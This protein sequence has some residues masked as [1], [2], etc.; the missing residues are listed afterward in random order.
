MNRF[1]LLPL[2]LLLAAATIVEAQRMTV[3]TESDAARAEFEQARARWAHVD[4]VGV[5]RHLDAALAADPGFAL[6]HLY[7]AASL[8]ISQ[9]AE[10]MR[11][12]EAARVSAG[13]RELIEAVKL[14]NAGD[15]E[16]ERAVY[17]KLAGE[18][19]NDPWPFYHLGGSLYNAERYDD[20]VAAY[21]R[22]IAADA[23]FPGAY[24]LLGYAE[25]QR[26][27]KAA[28]EKAFEQYIRLAPNEANPYDSM[29]EFYMLNGRLNE[30]EAQFKKALAIDPE[31][32]VSSDNLV[33]IALERR[34]ARFEQAV[35]NKDAAALAALYTPAGRLLPPNEA[36]VN[37][38][39]KIRE[40]WSGFFDAGFDG[41]DLTTDE[42]YVADNTAT[43]LSH[44]TVSMNG[45]VVDSGRATVV[46][47]KV[48]DDW[49]MH[50]D[51]WSSDR[52]ATGSTAGN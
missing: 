26:G 11:Q 4:F 45:E 12:A 36:N 32:T 27:N 9:R 51:M 44:W 14:H 6:A 20:A 1:L 49:L 21:K 25:M 31:L 28:A 50:R 48:G 29:G 16:R 43:E 41:I 34:N 46:W 18:F 38:R 19:P 7:R 33:R 40:Y 3:T 24:N 37:S 2:T 47:S 39:D 10:Q 8:P 35:A 17:M 42:V 23:R 30:A 13:E 15:H 22:A 52:A 5:E